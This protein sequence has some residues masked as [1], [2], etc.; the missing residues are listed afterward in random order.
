M[1]EPLPRTWCEID[2]SALNHNLLQIRKKVGPRRKIIAVIKAD[3]YG[4]GALAVAQLAHQLNIPYLGLATIDEAIALRQQGIKTPILLLSCCQNYEVDAVVEYQFI[5]NVCTLEVGKK[6]NQFAAKK[7]LTLLFHTEIDTGIGR[8]GAFYPE[9]GK[10]INQ[11]AQYP[12]LRLNGVFTHFASADD[13]PEFTALQFKRY[14]KTLAELAAAKIQVPFRHV[15]NSATVL[16]YPKMYLD[17]VRPGL[18]IYGLYPARSMQRLADLQSAM[19]LKSRVI[20]LKRAKPGRTISYG[21]TYITKKNT[22]IA[23]I[24]AGYR[25]GYPRLLSNLGEVL[26]HGN[27]VPIIGRICMDQF[28]VDVTRIPNVQLGDEVVLFGNQGKN[29]IEIDEVAQWASTISYEIVCSVGRLNKRV[30]KPNR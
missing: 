16:S 27:R 29:Q 5:P 9:A 3:A 10:L 15:A 4:H 24:S 13:N 21:R 23:T 18:I 12:Q 14:Q 20:Y 17:G 7:K 6:L 19:S 8:V 28:M 2:L 26:I 11:L 25:N 30:Y 22:T 1:S